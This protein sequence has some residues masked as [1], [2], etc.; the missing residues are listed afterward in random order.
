M[1]KT[2][3]KNASSYCNYNDSF[4]SYDQ[5]RQPNG[6]QEILNIFKQSRIPVEEQTI[7]EGGFGTGAYINHIRHHVKEIHGVE[8]SEK[9]YE[10]TRQKV[11]N[12]ENVHLQIGNILDL[13]FSDDFFD[14]YMVNQV[15]HHLDTEPAYPHLTL[16]LK[17]SRRVIKPGGVLTINTSSQEQLNPHSGAYWNY[18]YIEKAALAIQARYIPVPNLL[19]RLEEL[20]FTE[21]KT[22]LPSGNLFQ[23]R[24]YCDPRLVLDTDFQKADSIYCFYSKKQIDEANIL[25]RSSI[26]DGSVYQQMEH[27]AARAKEI[28]ESVI[29]SAR[30]PL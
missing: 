14:A 2:E 10:E 21:I 27:A 22:T 26:D 20:E 29:I 6:L 23:E 30:K 12:A 24:Y 1:K 18:K 4:I 19:S 15:L 13:S 8:G 17:E 3:K 28:G 11:G 5:N 7:L 9:G 25:I 16:F